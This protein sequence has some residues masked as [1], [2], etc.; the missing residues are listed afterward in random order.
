MTAFRGILSNQPARQLILSVRPQEMRT[1][2][3]FRHPAEFV[4]DQEDGGGI[5]A[6]RGA[7]WFAGLL[8]R[9]PALQLDEDLCQEDWGVV[10][11]ARRN[12][13]KFW[14]GLSAWDS[15]G[16]WVAHFH[17]GS[18]AWLQRFSLT[19]KNE[20]KRL[21]ADFHNVLSSE[22]LVTEIVW[23]EES[24]RSKPEPAGFP[25]PVEG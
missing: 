11:F 19:G 23:H 12:Q 17:H 3:T 13:K 1:N 18:F 14:V 9:V 22:S 16:A 20:L 5:L 7:Q 6:V 21:L 4:G 8:R 15:E 24:E 2:V 10:F 25:T